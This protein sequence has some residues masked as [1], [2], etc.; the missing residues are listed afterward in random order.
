MDV[1]KA[2]T[3][4]RPAAELYAYWHDFENLPRFMEHLEAVRVTGA[5]R[6]HWTAKAP[7]NQTVEW[8]AEVVEDRPNALI[9]WRSLD[10]AA[11]DN[12]GSVRFTPAPGDRGTEV[13]VE[14]RYDPPGGALGATVAKLFGEDPTQQVPDDLR[15]FKQVME[16]GEVTQSDASV[17]GGGPAQPP[18]EAPDPAALAKEPLAVKEDTSAGTPRS[19][20]TA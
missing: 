9:A 10:G 14:L 20:T 6:S 13:R 16:T 2:I 7:A 17:K 1:Q 8:D 3:I 4:N 19:V 15:R 12:A 11:V 5:G 18:A